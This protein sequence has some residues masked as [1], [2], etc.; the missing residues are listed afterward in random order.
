MK[1]ASVIMLSECLGPCL[2]ISNSS[3]KTSAAELV[4]NNAISVAEQSV[5]SVQEHQL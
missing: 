3:S 2:G 4:G 5:A 1:S